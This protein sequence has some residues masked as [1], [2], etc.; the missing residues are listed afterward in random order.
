M[1]ATMAEVLRQYRA[2]EISEKAFLT[3]SK[4]EAG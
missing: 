1:D 4:R 3:I 2:G